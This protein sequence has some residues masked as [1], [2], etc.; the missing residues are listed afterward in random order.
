MSITLKQF[1]RAQVTPKDDATLY[2]FL[3]G[4]SGIVKGCTVTH[5]EGDDAARAGAGRY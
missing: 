4:Q 5:L 3:I 1:D 2:D